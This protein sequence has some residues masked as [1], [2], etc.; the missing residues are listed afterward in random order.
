MPVEVDGGA[1]CEDAGGDA[2]PEPGWGFREVVLESELV[3]EGVDDRL[4]PLSDEANRWPRPVGLVSAVGVGRV[5]PLAW[6]L[7]WPPACA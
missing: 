2:G 1:E 3:F 4:D 7:A 6:P 5:W